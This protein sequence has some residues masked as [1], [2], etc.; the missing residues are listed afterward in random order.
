MIPLCKEYGIDLTPYSPL[1]RG[2]LAGKR[3]SIRFKNDDIAIKYYN[4]KSDLRIIKSTKKLQKTG[5]S[6]AEVAI[7]WLQNKPEIKSIILGP[8]KIEHLSSL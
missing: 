4:T 3:N 2:F 7:A 5:V 6:M 8:S 1:A